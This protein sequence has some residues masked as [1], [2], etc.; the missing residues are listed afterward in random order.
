MPDVP[1]LL[2]I[3]DDPNMRDLL[4]AHIKQFQNTIGGS[5]EVLTA[6]GWEEGARIVEARPIAG[7]LL[8]LT[9]PPD[10]ALQTLSRLAVVA[11]VWPP[12]VVITGNTDEELRFRAIAICG[13]QD[14]I[15][16]DE[17]QAGYRAAIALQHA[18]WRK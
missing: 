14:F 1:R 3:E 13:A 17:A 4:S 7:I 2:I 10:D 15:R 9:L 11:P 8:D 18:I 5:A 16:K 6:G 12:C